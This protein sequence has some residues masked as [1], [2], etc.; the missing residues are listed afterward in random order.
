M[1]RCVGSEKDIDIQVRGLHYL[2][3][4]KATSVQVTAKLHNGA[5]NY[6]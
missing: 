3:K 5:D 4:I 2:L 1:I 6:D